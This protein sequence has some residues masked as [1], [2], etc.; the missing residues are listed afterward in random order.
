FLRYK[1]LNGDGL[2]DERDK[3]YFGSYVPKFNYGISIGLDY[4]QIDFS[5]DAFG[6]GGNKVYNGL[7][8]QRC[9]GENITEEVFNNRWTGPGTTNK[10]PGANRDH[11]PSNYYLEDGSYLRIN[12]IT[13]GYTLTDIVKHV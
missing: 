11:L 6:V 8:S 2:I 9:G 5:V 12:N 10:H 7:V 13:L 3:R 1:D 4:K